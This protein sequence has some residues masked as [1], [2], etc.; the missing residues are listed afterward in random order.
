MNQT[1]PQPTIAL[2]LRGLL[3]ALVLALFGGAALAQET[4]TA[5]GGEEAVIQVGGET[6]LTQAQFEEEFDRA[7]RAL[8]RQ[9][10]LPFNEQTRALFDRFRQDFLNQLATQEA[11]L[12]EAEARGVTVPDEEVDAQIARAQESL[13]GEEAFTQAIQELGYQDM[14]A[15]RQYV[16][17]G[18]MAQRAVEELRAGLEITD[19]D[20]ST[21]YEQNQD[22]FGDAAL[23]D[24]QD[25]VRAQLE[26]ERL[27]QRFTELQAQYAVQTN[28]DVILAEDAEEGVAGGGEGETVEETEPAPEGEE[29]GTETEESDIGTEEPGVDTEEGEVEDEGEQTQ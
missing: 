8:A 7:I 20:V 16:R 4:A 9:Q 23:E 6:T 14:D 12:R 17:E 3:L 18:L 19:E 24:V 26:N 22:L 10:G 21:Y 27:T 1:A 15:Y 13:G 28:P 11:L 2:S 5:T 29:P 25:Q